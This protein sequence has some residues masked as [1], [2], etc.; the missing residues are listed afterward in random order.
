MNVNRASLIAIGTLLCVGATPALAQSTAAPNG[1]QLVTIRFEAAVGEQAFACG[2]RYD[3]IGITASTITASDFRFYVSNVRLIRADGADVPVALTPDGLWQQDDVALLDFE[4]GSRTC[5]NGTPELRDVVEGRVPAGRYSGLRFTVGVPFEKN[6]RDPTLQPSP[7]NLT[8][9][10]WT[11]NAG[12]KFLRLDLRTS[13]LPQGW[14]VHLGSTGCSP[15]GTPLDVP[16]ACRFPNDVRVDLPAFDPDGDAVRVDLRTLLA[17]AD[18]D[19]NQ[20]ETAA[21]CMSAQDDRDCAA[22]FQA[23]GLPFSGGPAGTQRVFRV[24]ARPRVEA[25]R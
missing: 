24:V 13:G 4:D 14:V 18:V 19:V 20:P 11:W 21:G 22:I 17:G 5:A 12:Y 23:F 1:T 16:T 7:L 10:F 6:H 8:R 25:G 9:M 3:G 2:T 15:G